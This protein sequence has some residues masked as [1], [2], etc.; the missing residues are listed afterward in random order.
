MTLVQWHFAKR[1]IFT[2]KVAWNSYL[3]PRLRHNC[4]IDRSATENKV[5][6]TLNIDFLSHGLRSVK[7]EQELEKMKIIPLEFVSDCFGQWLWIAKNYSQCNFT[8]QTETVLDKYKSYLLNLSGTADTCIE[9]PHHVLIF[10][11][12]RF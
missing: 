2:G 10:V 7:I 9:L 12:R 11:T 6:H 8:A 3:T 4:V 5:I 1:N